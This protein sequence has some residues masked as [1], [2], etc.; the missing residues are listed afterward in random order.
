M[1]ETERKAIRTARAKNKREKK[2]LEGYVILDVNINNYCFRSPCSLMTSIDIM[3]ENNTFNLKISKIQFNKGCD[4]YG[5][6]TRTLI[7]W[8]E[9]DNI[10][11]DNYN[12]DRICR[13]V[14]LNDELKQEILD[15]IKFNGKGIH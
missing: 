9:K 11:D 13:R 5:G 14:G 6:T 3:Q 1:T 7:L 15:D 8:H 12:I 10:V 2:R 4:M